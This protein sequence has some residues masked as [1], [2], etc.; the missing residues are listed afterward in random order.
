METVEGFVVVN[1]ENVRVARNEEVG[2]VG[3]DFRADASVVVAGVSADVF[4]QDVGL[5]HAEAQNFGEQAPH[6]SAVDIAVN[7]SQRAD[8]GQ[9]VGHFHGADVA[10][11][12]YF[13]A[14]GKVF[15]VALVPIAMGI[16][17]QSNS[18]HRS[19]ERGIGGLESEFAE[20]K[21]FDELCRGL[22]AEHGGIDAEVVGF[23]GSP[24][25][26]TVEVVERRALLVPMLHHA[27]GRLGHNV[28]LLADALHAVG[29]VGRD[30]YV[31]ATRMVAQDVVG[32]TT[33]EEARAALG[34]FADGVALDAEEV[35]VAHAAG[36]EISVAADDGRDGAEHGA[37]EA[38]ALV[39][40]L[41]QF[42][43]E[44]TL[45]GGQREDFL[46]VVGNT[47]FFGKQ[48]ADGATAAAQL[49]TNSDDIGTGVGG[50]GRTE[51]VLEGRIQLVLYIHR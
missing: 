11:V 39:V 5:L 6:I 8:V 1:F 43:V 13:I 21:L 41:E 25:V 24:G 50:D 14:L 48:F 7:G 46:V 42:G 2:R 15:F 26:G 30:E 47:Q 3:K 16:A 36:I 10:C 12:P 49:A 29:R 19:V 20:G 4:H 37:E 32:T 40:A 38:L 35:F 9:A 27:L 18:R 17:E 33:D 28:H 45:L 22:N 44:A 51:V 34:G 31:D 23:G